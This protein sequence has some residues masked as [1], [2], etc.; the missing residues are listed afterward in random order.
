[1]LRSMT[2]ID[3]E[4]AAAQ[5]LEEQ[6]DFPAALSLLTSLLQSSPSHPG[7]LLALARLSEAMGSLDDAL[8]LI[9]AAP[10]CS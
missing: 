1:M 8:V 9:E 2:T 5:R 10:A 3:A 7:I 6:G 4:I